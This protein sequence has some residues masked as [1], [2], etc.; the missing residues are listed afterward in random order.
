MLRAGLRIV[1]VAVA[2]GR[3]AAGGASA[4]P[5][6]T[7]RAGRRRRSR[8]SV[9]RRQRPPRHL[10]DD[11]FAGLGVAE[12][13]LPRQHLLS[14]RFQMERADR[15]QHRHPLAR[16][17]Q[18][19]RREA[20][21]ARRLRPLHDRSEVPRAEVGHPAEQ[22]A[23]SERTCASALSML[24]FR[25]MGLE[26]ERE[27]HAR[28]YINNAYAGLYT[29]VESLD[30]TFLTKNFGEN[31]GHLYEYS[32]DNA[33]PS[34]FN[35]GYPGATRRCIRRSRS[36]RRRWNSI[37]RARCIE[38][39]FWTVNTRATRCGGRRSRSSSTSRS[40]SATSR[41]RISSP[42]RTA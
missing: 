22:H 33:A 19:Q 41:S 18:P 28:L 5:R 7:P 17:R 12:G 32:F 2:R 3:G 9:L 30:K 38:R 34:P 8:R 27:A 15:P 13:A 42:R 14:V 39:L 36:S 26:A 16:H 20:G 6:R 35:F 31:D 11:Q 4:R 1:V 23:G 10:P 29:I 25:R 40:S 24:L 37:R 21:P